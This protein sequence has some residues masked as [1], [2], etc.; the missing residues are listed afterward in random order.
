MAIMIGTMGPLYAKLFHREFDDYFLKLAVS[1]VFWQLISQYITEACGAFISAEAFIKQIRLPLTIHVLKVVWKNGVIFCHNFLVVVAV[2]AYFQ[3]ALGYHLLL[4]PFA[5]FL[6]AVNAVWIGIV[7]GLLCA[8]FRDIPQ[9]VASLMGVA[10]FLTPVMWQPDML[11]KHQW[12]V[13]LNPFYH[14]IEIVR[15]PLVAAPVNVLSWIAVVAITVIG[16][17]VMLAMFSKYRS[18]IAYWV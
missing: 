17:A 9:I 6:L 10:F 12:V 14:F 8:R 4:L 7:L 15:A 13:N 3:P 16:I 5:L 1:L 2:L 18:R 11:G